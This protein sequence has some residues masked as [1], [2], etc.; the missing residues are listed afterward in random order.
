MKRMK[1]QN[2]KPD[3]AFERHN[4]VTIPPLRAPPFQM[5]VY[6]RIID[7]E[8]TLFNKTGAGPKVVL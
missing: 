1:R 7:Q 3:A 8:V 5:H 6:R 2:K 4:V